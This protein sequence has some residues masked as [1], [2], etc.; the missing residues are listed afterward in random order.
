MDLPYFDAL[1]LRSAGEELVGDNGRQAVHVA[2]VACER[3]LALGSAS[4]PHSNCLVPRGACQLIGANLLDRRHPGRVSA[5][6]GGEIGARRVPQLDRVVTRA[7]GQHT[8][9]AEQCYR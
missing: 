2:G 9:I 4:V 7:A 8:A 5:E 1:I 3:A 6:C